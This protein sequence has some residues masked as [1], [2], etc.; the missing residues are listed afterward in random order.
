MQPVDARPGRAG[1]L[2][3]RAHGAGNRPDL[4]GIEHYAD[5]LLGHA[6]S[7]THEPA[8]VSGDALVCWR[9][10]IAVKRRA[11]VLTCRQVS[12][13]VSEA[14]DRRLGLLERWRLRV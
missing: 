14:E 3:A 10:L 13:L 9:A 4:S 11:L 6:L 5:Q 12:H 7:R 1:V 2:H 8:P